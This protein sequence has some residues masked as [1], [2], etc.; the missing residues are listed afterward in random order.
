MSLLSSL[1][2]RTGLGSSGSRLPDPAVDEKEEG[3]VSSSVEGTMIEARDQGVRTDRDQESDGAHVTTRRPRVP[4][5]PSAP[6]ATAEDQVETGPGIP[7]FLLDR[8]EL[9]RKKRLESELWNGL[10]LYIVVMED[11][12]IPPTFAWESL[13]HL[14]K[15]YLT[16]I[17]TLVQPEAGSLLIDMVE[18]M[19]L[20]HPAIELVGRGRL[21]VTLGGYRVQLF[22]GRMGDI[23]ENLATAY[24]QL[25]LD[26]HFKSPGLHQASHPFI[27]YPCPSY[28]GL[29]PGVVEEGRKVGERWG[30]TVQEQ[31][32]TLDPASLDRLYLLVEREKAKGSE[33]P[34]VGLFPRQPLGQSYRGTAEEK[35]LGQAEEQPHRSMPSAPEPEET[36]R[37]PPRPVPRPRRHLKTPPRPEL[38]VEPE[39]SL[40]ATPPH[41]PVPEPPVPV[42]RPRVVLPAK[43]PSQSAFYQP[44]SQLGVGMDLGSSIG[45]G[46]LTSSRRRIPVPNLD[47]SP[48]PPPSRVSNPDKTAIEELSH[49]LQ[50][51]NQRSALETSQSLIK[52]L[53]EEGAFKSDTPRLDNFSGDDEV[54]GV[55]FE[56]WQYQV[57]S[58]K[59]SHKPHSIREAMIRSLKGTAAEVVRSLST[60][61]GWEDILEALKVKFQE[62]GTWAALSTKFFQLTKGE[63]SVSQ[64]SVQ[65]EAAL[66]SLAVRFPANYPPGTRDTHL[67]NKFFDGLPP[68]YRNGLRYKMDNPAVSYADLLQS[69]R[70]IEIEMGDNTGTSTKDKK[71]EEGQPKK[72]ITAAAVGVSPK[73]PQLTQME[74]LFQ[75]SQSQV[76]DLQG[77]VESMSDALAKVLTSGFDSQAKGSNNNSHYSG[78]GGK[79]R[80]RGKGSNPYPKG[81]GVGPRPGQGQPGWEGACFFCREY[82]PLEQCRHPIR[83]CTRSKAAQKGY[84]AKELPA[85]PQQETQPST[86]TTN[87][88]N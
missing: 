59:R 81:Q 20:Y 63:S 56:L 32:S 30:N 50:L 43:P 71:K 12:S 22:P 65:V 73:D 18:L 11:G 16:Y 77:K 25:L 27:F 8:G 14:F 86:S 9:A 44:P 67:K 39:E 1:W 2:R 80:G 3:E 17:R 70:E 10:I 82:L 78:K 5:E 68:S 87:Q 6:P 42:A 33:A 52:L 53:R 48:D 49:Q 75:A 29:P 40:P 7:S 61:A 55:S 69:A 57:L 35:E 88:E 58:L 66:H 21:L 28:T 38:E 79:G 37:R 72:K 51:L 31:L 45:A 74:Q 24:V 36:P 13:T 23:D 15:P 46:P 76:K 54:K 41:S 4:A 84:W 60:D 83:A 64:F 62:V 19:N 34:A 26:Y 85:S 47:L